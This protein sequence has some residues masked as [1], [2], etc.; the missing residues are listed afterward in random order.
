MSANKSASQTVVS[1]PALQTSATWKTIKLQSASVTQD[2][3]SS[4]T[5][6]HPTKVFKIL[7]AEQW[8]DWLRKSDFTGAS[9][10]IQDG[11]IHLSTIDQTVETHDKFFAGQKDPVLVLVDL[12][13]VGPTTLWNILA[14]LYVM[15]AGTV[16]LSR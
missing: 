13:K 6:E 4:M 14:V 5:S 7:T 2:L 10:D 11:Y 16:E 12:Q 1:D 9:I 8:A 15:R 3:K